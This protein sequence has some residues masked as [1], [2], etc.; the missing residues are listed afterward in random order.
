LVELVA[1]IYRIYVV[2]FEVGEHDNLG[3][4]DTAET[5]GMDMGNDLRRRPS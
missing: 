2:A 3:G 1:E 4:V 5:R